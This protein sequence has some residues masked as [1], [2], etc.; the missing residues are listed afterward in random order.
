MATATTNTSAIVGRLYLIPFVNGAAATADRIGFNVTTGGA[1]GSVA[2]CGIY[3]A[4][5]DGTF[6][7]D[8]LLVDGGEF[9]T[10][11]TGIK[12]ATISQALAA[13]TLYWFAFTAGTAAPQLSHSTLGN[14]SILGAPSTSPTAVAFFYFPVQTYGALPAT[15]PALAQES[16][17]SFPLVFVRLI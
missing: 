6:L 3:S 7:A 2:R 16:N 11:T 17:G 9:D 8:T 12:E 15:A 1:A 14:G 4:K 10:T 13:D 5:T